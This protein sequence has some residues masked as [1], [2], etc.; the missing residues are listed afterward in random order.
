MKTML[1]TAMAVFS[2]AQLFS[3]SPHE[4]KITGASDMAW[5]YASK[6]T[7]N[8]QGSEPLPSTG[9]QSPV[10]GANQAKSNAVNW[11]VIGGSSNVYGVLES[12]AKPLQ[13][14]DELNAI[15]F[16]HRKSSTYVS[17]PVATPVAAATGVILGLVSSNMG[18]TWDSTCIWNNNTYY[19]RYP[20]GGIY[21]PPGN[22]SI[23]N[24]YI[25]ATGPITQAAGGWSGSYLASKKLDVFSNAASTAPNA[26]QYAPNT[27]TPVPYSGLGKFDF[28]TTDFTSTDVGDL[29]AIGKIYANY[30]ATTAI[31]QGQRGA[32]LLKGNF[33]AGVFNWTPDSI[34]PVFRTTANPVDPNFGQQM[35]IRGLAPQM[36]WNESGTVGY[37]AFIGCWPNS[38]KSNSGY[39]PMIYKTTNSGASWSI[40]PAIDFNDLTTFA[41]VHDHLPAA[42]GATYTV[43]FFW[44]GEGMDMIVDKDN[45]L[46]FVSTVIGGAKSDP[47][48]VGYT[49]R[50]NNKDQQTY[51]FGHVPGLRPYIYDFTETNGGWKVMMID[52][53]SSEAPGVNVGDN[54]YTFNPWDPEV[55]SNNKKIEVDARIQLSRSPDG[56]FI[57]YTWA[58]SDSSFNDSKVK[59]N[60]YPNIKVRYFDVR[61]QTMSSQFNVTSSQSGASQYVQR[62]AYNKHVS[63]KCKL[64]FCSD[65]TVKLSIPMT[66]T[67]SFPLTQAVQN[68]HWYS[69]V[70]LS[71]CTVGLSE[72]THE[73]L[74]EAVIYPNPTSENATLKLTLDKALAV[75]IT[76]LNMLGQAVSVMEMQGLEGEN[77][78]SLGVESLPSGMYLVKLESGTTVSSKKLMVE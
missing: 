53:M 4:L 36:A 72:R 57:V 15:S 19:A 12:D 20:Q 54:G 55:S 44:Y 8:R 1:P 42:K 33:S 50:F 38:I 58:E 59:W 73:M 71:S 52:S 17:S 63:P 11:V 77:N 43:P 49:Y 7:L 10:N 34:I 74:Q 25:V 23:S 2:I 68:I 31:G 28:P 6:Y 76:V 69:T 18:T 9:L 21:N 41:S 66:I 40:L 78:F 61:S 5:Q 46:H 51:M 70:E 22:T 32:R 48:S 24:A 27:P 35:F 60:Q 39:Q 16:I 67:N 13:Y 45:K 47:D 3:Q 37:V 56:R 64:S 30:N 75:K 65:S 62:S 26:Q 29:H 14:N